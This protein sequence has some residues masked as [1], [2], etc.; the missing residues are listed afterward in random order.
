MALPL[1]HPFHFGPQSMF[2]S[3]MPTTHYLMENMLDYI[4]SMTSEAL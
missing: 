4:N 2:W 3:E 1:A